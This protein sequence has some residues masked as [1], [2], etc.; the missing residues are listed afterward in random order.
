MNADAKIDLLEQVPFLA[1]L[2]RDTLQE[3]AESALVRHY[4]ARQLV[5]SELEFGTDVF[6][7]ARGEAEVSVDSQ[8]G[9]RQ[10]LDRIGPGVAFGEMASLTGELRSATVR[11]VSELEL[12][13]IQDRDFDALR[14]RRPEVALALS[15]ILATRLGEAERTLASLLANR[16]AA[17]PRAVRLRSA[18]GQLWRELVVNYQKDL[19][20]L[21]LVA[22][23][24]TLLFVRMAVF[25]AFEFDYAPREVLRVAYVSGFGLVMTSACASLLT[26]RPRWRRAICLAFGVGAALIV[27]ELGV[28]LAF[29]IFYKD[30]FTPDPAVPFDI[31]RLYRRT[32]PLRA[33]VIGLLLLLQ[34]VYLRSFYGRAAYLVRIRLRQLLRI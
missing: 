16:S 1:V 9:E 34:A 33:T 14:L 10:V 20:F 22:F 23:V 26:F 18:L 5:V 17:T 32:E 15:R 7:I 21:M 12:L 11:A 2:D 31:E 25:F 8:S 13:V 30:I 6:V 24:C 19:A 3:L 28:T 29:D 4:R 27:N